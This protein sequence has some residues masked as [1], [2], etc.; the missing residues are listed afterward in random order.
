MDRRKMKK[1]IFCLLKQLLSV[2]L[3]FLAAPLALAGS[4]RP[5]DVFLIQNSGWMEAFYLDPSSKFKPTVKKLVHEAT[6]GGQS[7]DVVICSFNE[8]LPGNPSPLCNYRGKYDDRKIGNV[9]DS[10]QLA[11]KPNSSALADTNFVETIGKI[12]SNL[13]SK[14]QQGILW[15]VTNN[16]NS[17]NNNANT[18]ALNRQYYEILHENPAIERVVAFPYKMSLHGPHYDASG[19]MVYGIAFGTNAGQELKRKMT[20]QGLSRLFDGALPARLKPLNEEAVTFV[21]KGTKKSADV[22]VYLEK[23]GKTLDIQFNASSAASVV[24]IQGVFRN[25]FY[26]YTINNA[27][28]NLVTNLDRANIK[29]NISINALQKLEPGSESIPLVIHMELPPLKSQWN[30]EVIFKSGYKISGNLQ[31][32]LADQELSISK[33]F[34]EK[35]NSLFPQVPLPDLFRPSSQSRESTTTIPVVVSVI[36]PIWPLVV[37]L[38]G[39]GVLIAGGMASWIASR[40]SKKIAVMI[41]HNKQVINMG[42]GRKVELR[43]E[44]GEHVATLSRTMF[45]I[46]LTE[47]SNQSIVKVIK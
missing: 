1:T 30:P 37:L 29:N 45:G 39:V 7:D 4:A 27:R 38:S 36:Y 43:N 25:D 47:I 11:Y 21:P 12:T 46:K 18:V 26:P 17:P 42:A 13:E 9:I 14:G 40:K 33:G 41:D 15:I 6:N 23:D 44:A 32:T 19:L 10:I 20:S 31:L 5:V 3:L 22:E 2:L 34:S 16:K 24:D 28:V 35:M 8:A